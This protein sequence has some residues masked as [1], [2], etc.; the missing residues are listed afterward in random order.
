MNVTLAPACGHELEKAT[1][2]EPRFPLEVLTTITPLLRIKSLT[3]S[4][5]FAKLTVS[6]ADV[7]GGGLV[8]LL[9]FDGLFAS[10]F[11]QAFIIQATQVRVSPP[12]S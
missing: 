3:S 7:P 4:S 2:F 8:L 11:E 6:R 5:W 1:K 12:V 9:L 10:S